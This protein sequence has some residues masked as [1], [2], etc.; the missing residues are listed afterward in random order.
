MLFNVPFLQAN[1]L[2]ATTSLNEI[3][4]LYIIEHILRITC[5]M[6]YVCMT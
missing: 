3:S 5:G 1:K 6:H 4:E 2:T